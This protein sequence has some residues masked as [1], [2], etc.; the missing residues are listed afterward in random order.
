M[1][2]AGGI[3]IKLRDHSRDVTRKVAGG[4]GG[5]TPRTR[6]GGQRVIRQTNADDPTAMVDD[7]QAHVLKPSH[8]NCAH[9][10]QVVSCSVVCANIKPHVT[11][12]W[13][14]KHL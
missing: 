8:H 13:Y 4:L 3:S 5:S 12:Q 2:V 9:L 1:Q 14:G 11:L 10:L 6:R 7:A